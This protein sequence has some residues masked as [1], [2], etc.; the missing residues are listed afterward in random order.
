MEGEGG[1]G[2]I[3]YGEAFRG[4]GGR[5]GLGLGDPFFTG[6]SSVENEILVVVRKGPGLQ[7]AQKS[8]RA[9]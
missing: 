8:R 7:I 6:I 4:G 5:G 1:A 2:V 9:Y 3:G